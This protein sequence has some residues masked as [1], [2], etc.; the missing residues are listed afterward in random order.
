M[1]IVDK[2]HSCN[3]EGEKKKKQKKTHYTLSFI[4]S[5]KACKPVGYMDSWYR[6]LLFSHSVVSDFATPWTAAHQASMSLTIIQSFLKLTSI[7]SVMPSNHLLLCHPLLL[8]PSDF[9]SIRV[10]CNKSA[11]HIRGPKYWSFSTTSYTE[12]PGLFPVGLTSLISLQ[13]KGLSRVLQHC[14]LKAS[15]LWQSSFF[16]VQ[17]PHPYM[18]TGKTIALTIWTFVSKV[19]FLVVFKNS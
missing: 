5:L 6:P 3:A 19:M 12:I 13:S 14:S 8:L 17:L 18:T 16:R 1:N 9:S 15:I 4:W 10:C 7:E 11:L 2:S